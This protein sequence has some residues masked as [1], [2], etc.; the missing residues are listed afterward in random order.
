MVIRRSVSAIES[1]Q[2][3]DTFLP[4]VVLSGGH[5]EIVSNPGAC[6]GLV[7]LALH[8]STGTVIDNEKENNSPVA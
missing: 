6:F 7:F 4:V 8:S 3:E 1:V 5:A 2:L